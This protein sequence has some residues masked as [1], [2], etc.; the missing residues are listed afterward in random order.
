MVLCGHPELCQTSQ[1]VVILTKLQMPKTAL[2]TTETV[3]Q[4]LAVVLSAWPGAPLN[5]VGSFH[6]W[7]ADEGFIIC[8]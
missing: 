8:R 6:G 3:V 4:S 7:R 1:D 2:T 5:L